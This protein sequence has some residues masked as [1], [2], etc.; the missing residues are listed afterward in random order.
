MSNNLHSWPCTAYG[1]RHVAKIKDKQAMS[2]CFDT[3]H[4]NTLT[5]TA[6][7]D[8]GVINTNVY[9]IVFYRD[10]ISTL[11]RSTVDK[12]HITVCRILVLSMMDLDELYFLLGVVKRTSTY[13]EIDQRICIIFHIENGGGSL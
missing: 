3:A 8:V 5:T 4:A 1:I 13:L 10:V 11:G 2:V 6:G 12:L 9:S 7:C